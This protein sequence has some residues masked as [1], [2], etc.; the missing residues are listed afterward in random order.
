VTGG[1]I[2]DSIDY[3]VAERFH[4]FESEHRK[5]GGHVLF[6]GPKVVMIRMHSHTLF[7]H[8]GR[9]R[10]RRQRRQRRQQHAAAGQRKKKKKEELAG[11]EC[12]VCNTH[13]ISVFLTGIEFCFTPQKAARR[14]HCSCVAC[15]P[16]K[17]HRLSPLLGKAE[18]VQLVGRRLKS[19]GQRSLLR[20]VP[21]CHSRRST[22]GLLPQAAAAK[23]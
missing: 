17:R 7:H 12:I 1:G 15:P 21:T 18:P 16:V 23:A 20:C 22:F 5:I 8:Q 19:Q 2:H 14:W 10:R 13:C 9:R 11:D 6:G 4:L 3:D